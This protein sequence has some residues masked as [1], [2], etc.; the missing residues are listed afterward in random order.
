MATKENN[1]RIDL[2]KWFIN[3]VVIGLLTFFFTW[4]LNE[5]KQ[6]VEEIKVYNTYVEL[7]TKVDGLAERRLLAEFFSNVTV[8]SKLKEGWEDYYNILDLQYKNE[9]SKQDSIIDKIDTS[10]IEGKVELENAIF[11]KNTIEN[12][13]LTSPIIADIKT[14]NYQLALKKELEGFVG[15]LDKDIENAITAFSSSENAY[16]SF[17]QVYEIGKYLKEKNNSK[18]IKDDNFWKSIYREMLEI[19]S[20]KMPEAIKIEFIEIIQN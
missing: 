13:G 3:T 8:S 11:I 2:L 12:T 19:Y 14:N 16:N 18:D 1:N 15:L 4:V 17:H 9:L 10:T 5:R 6:G 20:W 7:V